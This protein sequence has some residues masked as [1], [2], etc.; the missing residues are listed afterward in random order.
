[1]SIAVGP[2]NTKWFAT[3]GGGVSRYDG[4]LIVP[5]ENAPEPCG[6]AILANRPNPFNPSTEI[7]FTV[8][9]AG[10]ATLAVYDITGRKVRDLVSGSLAAGVH[11][12]VWDGADNRGRA[13]SSGVY[14]SRLVSGNQ[15]ISRKMLLMR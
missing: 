5:V 4:G 8:P 3:W 13:V 14:F 10:K 9:K 15:S 12:V 2:D 11:T 6:L 7:G 1:M